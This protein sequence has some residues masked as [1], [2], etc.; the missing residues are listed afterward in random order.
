[1][2]LLQSKDAENPEAD[3]CGGRKGAD[4]EWIR[5][6]AESGEEQRKQTAVLP[7]AD[8]MFDGDKGIGT[9][10]HNGRSGTDQAGGHK[11]QRENKSN[12][13]TKN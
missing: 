11:L 10:I 12:T 8:N 13:F 4:E 9:E 6:V 5:T 1:M 2:V 3:V 7:H